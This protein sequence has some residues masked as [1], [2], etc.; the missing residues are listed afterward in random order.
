MKQL[1]VARVA[2]GQKL[3]FGKKYETATSSIGS[4]C[5]EVNF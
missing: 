4:F 3:I 1:Q 2:F 5:S